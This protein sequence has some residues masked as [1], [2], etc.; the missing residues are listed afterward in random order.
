[1]GEQGVGV[2]GVGALEDDGSCS[3]GGGSFSGQ[4]RSLRNTKFN[5]RLVNEVQLYLSILCLETDV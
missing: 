5:L 2:I 4:V 3:E 1:M